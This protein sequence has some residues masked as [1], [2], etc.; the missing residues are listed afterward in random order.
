MRLNWRT[1]N[2]AVLWIGGTVLSLVAQAQE[3]SSAPAREPLVLH[4]RVREGRRRPAA[5]ATSPY[6]VKETGPPVGPGD[7]RRSSSA[8]CGTSTGARGRPAGSASWP[9]P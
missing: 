5:D 6:V 8:T 7:G 9:P 2:M 3:P 1:G 4:A